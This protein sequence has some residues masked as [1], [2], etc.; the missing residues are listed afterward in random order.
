[1]NTF[2]IGSIDQPLTIQWPPSHFDKG[3]SSR[4]IKCFVNYEKPIKDIA[5][6]DETLIKDDILRLKLWQSA[7]VQLHNSNEL[8]T[9]DDLQQGDLI[10]VM[11]KPYKWE[12]Q[13]RQGTSL[14]AS[15]VLIVERGSVERQSNTPNWL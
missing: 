4:G 10:A 14:T 6:I 7:K 9:V 15:H 1:M 2:Q 13:G 3:Q 5:H 11:A 12:F 8:L